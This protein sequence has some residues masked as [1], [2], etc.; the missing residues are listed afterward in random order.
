MSL[1]LSNDRSVTLRGPLQLYH[2]MPDHVNSTAISSI[3][4]F[5]I[6]EPY[7]HKLTDHT[8]D[9]LLRRWT[10]GFVKQVSPTKN[11]YIWAIDPTNPGEIGEWEVSENSKTTSFPAGL[12]MTTQASIVALVKPKLVEVL[13]S[14]N[15][16]E[17]DVE[18]TAE[19][20]WYLQ[21]AMT[22]FPVW[23]E[24]GGEQQVPAA[25]RQLDCPMRSREEA[26]R[27]YRAAT[28]KCNEVGWFYC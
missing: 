13:E 2:P 15:G 1:D 11:H 9:F 5:T 27:M 23:L 21:N 24:E 8:S 12:A 4:S 22:T 25:E 16:M 28:C 7:L 17:T 10:I 19:L 14:F 26:A 6:C 18:L 3:Q 20:L